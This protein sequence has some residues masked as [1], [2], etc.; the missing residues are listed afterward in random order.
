MLSALLLLVVVVVVVVLVAVVDIVVVGFCVCVKSV[1]TM[2][3]QIS[4]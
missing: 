1:I 2:M 4:N 3:I